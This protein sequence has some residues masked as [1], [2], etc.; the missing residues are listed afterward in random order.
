MTDVTDEAVVDVRARFT[1]SD[2]R[3]ALH[4]YMKAPPRSMFRPTCGSA[5]VA[6]TRL[7]SFSWY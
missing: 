7:K 3:Q 2:C 6:L 4:N 1:A 5:D